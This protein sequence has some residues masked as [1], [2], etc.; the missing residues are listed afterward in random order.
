[1]NKKLKKLI[2]YSVFYPIK[3]LAALLSIVVFPLF[4]AFKMGE[5]WVELIDGLYDSINR[6]RR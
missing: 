6:D 5:Q 3:A 4:L 1:M 2:F